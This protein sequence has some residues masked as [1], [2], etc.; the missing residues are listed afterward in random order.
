[1]MV[2]ASGDRSIATEINAGI[3]SSGD[4][5]VNIRA[6]KGSYVAGTLYMQQVAGD[7]HIHGSG[8]SE[9]HAE[10]LANLARKLDAYSEQTAQAV[11]SLSIDVRSALAS[12]AP[13]VEEANPPHATE[14][15]EDVASEAPSYSDFW[16]FEGRVRASEGDWAAVVMV[17]DAFRHLP[18]RHVAELACELAG[19]ARGRVEAGD[20]WTLVAVAIQH[21]RS[22]T[23]ALSLAEMLQIAGNTWAARDLRSSLGQLRPISEVES[24]I[25]ILYGD[26]DY[27]TLVAVLSGIADRKQAQDTEAIIDYLLSSPVP[28]HVCARVIANIAMIGEIPSLLA[29]YEYGRRQVS[30]PMAS[31]VWSIAEYRPPVQV[32]AFLSAISSSKG[33]FETLKV[34]T[35]AAGVK[36]GRRKQLIELV[37]ELRLLEHLDLVEGA[38]AGP[39]QFFTIEELGQLMLDTLKAGRLAEAH[40]IAYFA[41]G[42]RAALADFAALR[43]MLSEDSPAV[44]A[45]RM[46]LLSGFAMSAA[47]DDICLA[48]RDL[49]EPS[50]EAIELVAAVIV[51]RRSS[52]DIVKALIAGPDEFRGAL[53]GYVSNSL[54]KYRT[55]SDLVAVVCGLVNAGA[56]EYL[57]R[58][59]AVAAVNLASSAPDQFVALLREMRAEGLLEQLSQV[60]LFVAMRLPIPSI[61]SFYNRIDADDFKSCIQGVYISR[62]W[63]DV[64]ELARG[65]R[66]AGVPE[67][68][69]WALTHVLIY[70]EVADALEI[71]DALRARREGFELGVALLGVAKFRPVHLLAPL[72]EALHPA[73][74]SLAR[75]II[76]KYGSADARAEV[77]V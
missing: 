2:S 9:R 54:Y 48:L 51:I 50:E 67:L 53:R 44:R 20:K 26:R 31:L 46:E 29:V 8:D 5:A 30:F 70:R 3:V 42:V 60:S 65:L 72:L 38:L 33:G 15:N 17:L 22:M 6:E 59:L 47:I 37:D 27:D 56:D 32:A 34:A 28:Q 43:D 66:Q 62:P 74:A 14:A 45:V 58:L 69:D 49:V 35:I 24:A 13:K 55:V 63:P 7:V 75:D 41:A 23:E 40:T 77:G 61:L 71:A 12:L 1:M 68:A 64:E 21:T 18:L 76:A 16:L 52:D 73:D 19:T 39:A 25:D 4:N 57:R 11:W 36:L 10:Q